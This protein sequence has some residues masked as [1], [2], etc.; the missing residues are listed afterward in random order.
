MTV[1]RLC[2]LMS[3]TQRFSKQEVL[4]WC[5]V[6][7]QNQNLGQNGPFLIDFFIVETLLQVYNQAMLSRKYRATRPNIEDTIK[8]G[9]SVFGK[10]LYAKIS[11]KESEKVG[12]AIVISK[13]NEKTSVGRHFI[14]RKISSYIEVNLPKINKEFKKTVVFFIKKTKEPIDYKEAK[15]DVEFVFEQVVDRSL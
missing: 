15:K 3:C 14:K 2:L 7:P 8:T 10:F 1:A 11:R 9:A 6:I 5:D 13:K 4:L 12:F